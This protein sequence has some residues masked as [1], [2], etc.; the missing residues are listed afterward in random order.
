MLGAWVGGGWGV[1]G[2]W[3]VEKELGVKFGSQGASG[4]TNGVKEVGEESPGKF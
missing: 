4:I 3:Q 2:G 1:G